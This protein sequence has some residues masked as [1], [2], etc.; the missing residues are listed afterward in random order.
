LFLENRGHGRALGFRLSAPGTTA[1]IEKQGGKR[2][3]KRAKK[4]KHKDREAVGTASW[5][6]CVAMI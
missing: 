4:W 2:A 6:Q 5:N 1:K 3:G